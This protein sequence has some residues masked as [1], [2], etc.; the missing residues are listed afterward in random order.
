MDIHNTYKRIGWF[1]YKSR[2]T[3]IDTVAFNFIYQFYIV[4]VQT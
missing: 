2:S 3:V 1:V 4:L